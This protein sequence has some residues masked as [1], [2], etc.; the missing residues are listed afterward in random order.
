MENIIAY[1]NGSLSNP[2]AGMPII[3]VYKIYRVYHWMAPNCSD[4]KWHD[5]ATYEGARE[6]AAD[7][8][9]RGYYVSVVVPAEHKM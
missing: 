5:H 2:K 3:S 6:E 7:W 4:S 8:E 1:M 9:A